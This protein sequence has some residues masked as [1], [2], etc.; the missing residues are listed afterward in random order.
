MGKVHLH[1]HLGK[2]F[3]WHLG[4]QQE[5]SLPLW[6]TVRLGYGLLRSLVH[7]ILQREQPGHSSSA[8]ATYV[9]GCDHRSLEQHLPAGH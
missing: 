9:L 2:D 5:L 7:P 8:D 3:C 6:H 1:S 4:F